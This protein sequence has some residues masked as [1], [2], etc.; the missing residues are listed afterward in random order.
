MKKIWSFLAVAMLLIS[1][2]KKDKFAIEVPAKVN[3]NK[4]FQIKTVNINNTSADSLIVSLDN[5]KIFQQVYNHT[6]Q[7]NP[8]NN[9]KLGKHNLQVKIKREGKIIF[10]QDFPLEI[11]AGIKPKVYE[12]KLI[13]SY[14]HDPKAFTQGLEFHLDT[15]YEGTG[16]NG[17]SGLRKTDYKNG[18][19]IKKIDLDK[20]YFGEGITILHNK[21]YQLTWQNKIG[22]VYDLNF[23]KIKDFKY[24]QSKEGWGLCND[25]KALYKSDGT[26]KIWLLDPDTLEEKSFINVYTDKHKIKKINELEWV[27]GLIFTNIWTKNA[28]AIINPATGE[29]TGIINLS[30]LISK[31]DPTIKHDVLNGIAYHPET[32]HLFVTGKFWDKVF[33]LEI[34]EEIFKK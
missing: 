29:V 23:N 19:I 14:P 25:G 21:V 26:E 11:Y 1:C 32:G 2:G 9:I 28:I 24:G 15:L 4:T 12:Y 30:K 13:N 8:G 3:L 7:I 34:P 5:Q 20:K 18:R 10:K 27:N 16:L 6:N 22:F 33:E 31:L 17:H